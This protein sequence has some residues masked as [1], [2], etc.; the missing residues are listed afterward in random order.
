MEPSP[1]NLKISKISF[2]KPPSKSS[3]TS[4]NINSPAVSEAS[5]KL[6]DDVSDNSSFENTIGVSRRDK[7]L[8][9]SRSSYL[10]SKP[11]LMRDKPVP[12]RNQKLTDLLKRRSVSLGGAAAKPKPARPVTHGVGMGGTRKAHT[13]G[14]E[15]SRSL[16]L[17]VK[18]KKAEPTKQMLPAECA[19]G[20]LGSGMGDLGFISK[21]IDSS[22]EEIGKGVKAVKTNADT[23]K[24]GGSGAASSMQLLSSS[25]KMTKA[26]ALMNHRMA[27]SS[28]N[29]SNTTLSL[30]RLEKSSLKS[31]KDKSKTDKLKTLV[32]K[33]ITER[34]KLKKSLE[35]TK[36]LRGSGNFLGICPIVKTEGKI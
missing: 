18:K 7:N 24:A 8:T 27:D 31:R 16:L 5:I 36:R 11:V 32:P 33:P 13:M 6:H 17:S 1:T 29:I 15:V 9:A 34:E 2:K 22:K 30:Q 23:T 20:S 10:S 14:G 19:L 4:S 12:S 28:S 26:V 35:L 3:S 21:C 25:S